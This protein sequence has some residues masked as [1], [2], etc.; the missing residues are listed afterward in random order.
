MKLTGVER[1]RELVDKIA[2]TRN[3]LDLLDDVAVH[4]IPPLKN[5]HQ[6][7]LDLL[8]RVVIRIE[9]ERLPLD[10]LSLLYLV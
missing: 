3:H 1:I 2:Q 6:L 9:V 8:G 7:L 10:I 5:G 4:V